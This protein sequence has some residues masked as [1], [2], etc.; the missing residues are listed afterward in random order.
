MQEIDYGRKWHVMVAV[1]MGIFLATIDGSIVNLALP[2]LVRDLG[3]DFATVQWVVLAYLLTVATLL[4]GIGRLADMKGKKPIYT[5]GFIVFTIGSLLCGLAPSIYWLIAFRVLQA[6]GAAM[7][8]A[9]GAAILTEAFPPSERGKALG[10][11]GTV[12]SLGIVV[13][14][15]LGGIL[16]EAISWHAIFF[17]NLPVGVVGTALSM[18]F[19]PAIRPPGG[20]TFDLWGAIAMFSSL[21]CLS[22]A[23]T[24]GQELGFG[25]GRILAL[26]AGFAVFL[27]TFVATEL[28]IPQPMIDLRLFQNRQLSV[29]LVTGFITFV[30]V[31]GSFILMPFYLENVRG[32][33]TRQVG[34][35]LVAVPIGLGVMSPI[36]GALSDRL[37]TRLIS[38]IGLAILLAGYY[39]LSTLDG[40]TNVPGFLLRFA[41][42]GVGMGIFQSPNNSAIMGSAPRERLGIVSGLLAITRTIGQTTGIAVLGAMWASRVFAY[43]GNPLPGG[44]TA[45]PAALQVSAL[46]DTYLGIFALIAFGLVLGIWALVEEQRTGA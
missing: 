31:A 35:L 39:A 24:V 17:V 27:A 41:P 20:Q 13:G 45:A 22:L 11:F 6:V 23:L 36:S 15:T 38:V 21:L 7:V 19:V 34:L 40:S 1:A 42:I 28:Q 4:L 2:T 18:R 46:R 32:F 9:L 12:V 25:D 3:A 10:L 14:P 5:A 8:V 16:I 43:A 33:D 29:N 37:G 30:A 44:A 26:F